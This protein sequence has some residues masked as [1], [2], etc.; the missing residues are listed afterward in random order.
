MILGFLNGD[1]G[2]SMTEREIINFII[3]ELERKLRAA[4]RNLRTYQDRMKDPTISKESRIIAESKVK[5]YRSE[6]LLNTE[7]L[8]ALF[9]VGKIV[10]EATEC[11]LAILN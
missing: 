7:K 3:K 2:K 10:E 11:E 9:K 4:E 1:R 8:L 5:T 6:I